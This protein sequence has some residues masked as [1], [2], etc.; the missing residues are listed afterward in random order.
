MSKDQIRTG[1]AQEHWNV[2]GTRLLKYT[3]EMYHKGLK[4]HKLISAPEMDML[5][6]KVSLQAQKWTEK[7]ESLESKRRINAEKEGNIEEANSRSEAA[8]KF[9][10][11][12][13]NLLIHTL[14]I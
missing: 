13:E 10:A 1:L 5:E 6:N 7:W 11:E 3:V 2:S 9:L 8:I 12:I 14:S 4:E